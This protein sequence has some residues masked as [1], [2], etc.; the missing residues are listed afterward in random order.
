MPNP[1]KVIVDQWRVVVW[2]GSRILLDEL[3]GNLFHTNR[4]PYVRYVDVETGE[5]WG[6]PLLPGTWPPANRL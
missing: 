4:H 6:S 3:A 1:M 5:F 2:A